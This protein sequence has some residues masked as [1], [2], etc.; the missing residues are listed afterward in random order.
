MNRRGLLIV[1]SALWL[2]G[3]AAGLQY[4]SEKT[5]PPRG[6]AA[7]VK[8][9]EKG[10]PPEPYERIGQITWE[11]QRRKFTPPQLEEIADQLKQKAWE[12]GGD[13]IVVRKLEEPTNP[14]GTL[15]VA[16]DVVRFRR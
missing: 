11:Y 1:L 10:E 15:R 16:A 3:C 8:I 14:E 7:D 2:A 12:A 6:T 4:T 9:I 13:A 5:Y